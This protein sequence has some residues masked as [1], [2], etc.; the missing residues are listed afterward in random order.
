MAAAEKQ[1]ADYVVVGRSITNAK[2]PIKTIK[3]IRK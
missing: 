3:T 2:D 1:G